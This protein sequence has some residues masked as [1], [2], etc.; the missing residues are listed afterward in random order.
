MTNIQLFKC[1]V[2]D[3]IS[4]LTLMLEKARESTQ[5][6]QNL[7]SHVSHQAWGSGHQHLIHDSTQQA[8]TDKGDDIFLNLLENSF[9]VLQMCVFSIPFSSIYRI[10]YPQSDGD[11]L[12]DLWIRRFITYISLVFLYNQFNLINKRIREH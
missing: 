9:P 8:N 4:S 5:Y 1:Y 12:R 3:D 11:T 7:N 10:G 2:P 6:K